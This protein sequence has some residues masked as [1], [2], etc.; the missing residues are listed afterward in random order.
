MAFLLNYMQK[1]VHFMTADIIILATTQPKV[2]NIEIG[3]ELQFIKNCNFQHQ[4]ITLFKYENKTKAAPIMY[5]LPSIVLQ[6]KMLL[7]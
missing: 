7:L 3:E 4:M 6:L 1:C 2:K 5:R